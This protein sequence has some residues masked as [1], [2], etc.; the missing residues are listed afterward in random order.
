MKRLTVIVPMAGD[1]RRFVEAGYETPKPFI[2]VHG[3]P[4]IELVLDNLSVGGADYHLIARRDHVDREPEAANRL[5]SGRNVTI[6]LIDERTEGTACTLLTAKGKIPYD[7]PLVIA[8][9]DQFVH[10]GIDAFVAD[11]FER[12]LDGSILVFDSPPDP[13]WSYARCNTVGQV[14]E[15]AE[16][17]PISNLATVGIYYFRRAAMF[18]AS[19]EAMIA[20]DDRVNGEFYTCPTYNYLVRSGGRVGV[21]EIPSSWMFG[22]GT[23]QDLETFLVRD[24]AR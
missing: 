14:L 10:G 16:K 24:V 7:E 8:N 11:A 3:I 17:Q 1:G 22:V 2:R 5:V 6:S 4:L 12:E 20:A 15:V 23:P 21:F 13:K 9:S 19:A 18:F